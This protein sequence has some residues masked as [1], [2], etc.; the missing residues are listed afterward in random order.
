MLITKQLKRPLAVAALALSF[1]TVSAEAAQILDIMTAPLYVRGTWANFG[2]SFSVSELVRVDALGL[3]DVGANG[4]ADEHPVGLWN[5]TGDMLAQ[6]IIDN[7]S[8]ASASVNANHAWRFT[9][10]EP[11]ILAPGTYKMGAFYPTTADAF[12]GSSAENPANILF[13]PVITF[14]SSYVTTGGTEFFT[15]PNTTTGFNPG[16]FGPNARFT[17]VPEPATLTCLALGGLMLIRRRR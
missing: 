1:C 7:S 11:I 13:S 5:D 12:A 9:D 8:T 16:F 14:G 17:V 15:E 10:I 4:F 2:F 6:V 3:Y